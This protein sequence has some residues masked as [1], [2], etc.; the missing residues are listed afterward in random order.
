MVDRLIWSLLCDLYCASG[1][2]TSIACIVM[3]YTHVISTTNRPCGI[4]KQN[5]GHA[6]KMEIGCW[7]RCDDSIGEGYD[8]PQ[9]IIEIQKKTRHKVRLWEQ[10]VRHCLE[11][12]GMNTKVLIVRQVRS[13]LTVLDWDM[14]DNKS[15][16]CTFD[17]ALWYIIQ[18]G[19]T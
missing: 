15:N 12:T 13:E 14:Y 8:L 9:T 1:H 17:I 18:L 19:Q 4:N 11:G 6:L 16:S 7:S 10:R 5:T 3:W 2:V